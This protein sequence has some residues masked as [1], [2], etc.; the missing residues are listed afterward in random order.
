M[1]SF[2]RARLRVLVLVCLVLLTGLSSARCA[3]AQQGSSASISGTVVDSHGSAVGRASVMVKNQASGATG[4][5]TSDNFGHFSFNGLAAGRYTLTV[6]SN[7]FA[8][9]V[10][11]D[12]TAAAQPTALTVALKVGSI[13]QNVEVRHIAGHSIAAQHA[14]S[15]STLDTETPKSEIGSEFIR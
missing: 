11:Q 2:F 4:Q 6:D 14:L 12:V 13:E 10:Q 1:I 8:E 7:G 3:R 9:S 15:Q 5:T